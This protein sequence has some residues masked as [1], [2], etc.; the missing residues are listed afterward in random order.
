MDY[1]RGLKANI[2]REI[3]DKWILGGELEGV[4]F[5]MQESVQVVSGP[6]AGTTGELTC[7]LALEPEPLFHL[8]TAD[9][10]DLWVYQSE[11]LAFE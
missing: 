9:G 7:V 4:R 6:H 11:I 3:Q 2:D 8:E 10:G 1:R 5:H